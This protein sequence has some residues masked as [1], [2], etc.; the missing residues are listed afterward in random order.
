MVP[1]G[2]GLTRLPSGAVGFA[3]GALPGELIAVESLS[4]RSGFL[5]AQAFRVLEPSSDRVEPRCSVAHSCGGCDFAHVAYPAQLRFKADILRDAL[6][7]VGGF[8]EPPEVDVVASPRPTRYRSRLRLHVGR[9]GQVGFFARHSHRLI[10]PESCLVA[11]EAL[12][13]ALADLLAVA[14]RHPRALSEYS[15]IELR[16]APEGPSPLARLTPRPGATRSAEGRA[17]FA[18]EL[19]QR[20]SV[21]VTGGSSDLLQRFPLEHGGFLAVPPDAFVQVNWEVNLALGRALAAGARAR[22]IESFFDVYSGTGNLLLVLLQAGLRGAGVEASPQAVRAARDNLTQAG[23]DP[24]LILERSAPEGLTRL[25]ERFGVPDLVVLDP[26]RA[27]AQQV[28]DALI[29]HRPRW[30]AALSCDPATFARDLGR[31]RREGYRLEGVQGFDMFP[32]THH[33]EALGWLEAN[34]PE[35]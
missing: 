7:H 26:P 34:P 32:D 28:L 12:D 4:R 14:E 2:L 24:S 19:S 11:S 33:L 10:R 22:Q 9:G 20:L 8:T 5:E 21:A 29:T 35:S 30:V 15:E 17:A 3:E 23:H 13:G 25:V 18:G 31:L 6:R 1:G 16:V 27:G